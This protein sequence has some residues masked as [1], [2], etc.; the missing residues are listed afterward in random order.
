MRMQQKALI[1][2]A[3]PDWTNG[4]DE[5][6]MALQRGWRVARL[7]PMGGAGVIAYKGTPEACFAAL[8]VLERAVDAE[9]G[10]MEQV[11]EYPEE[12]RSEGDGAGGDLGDLGDR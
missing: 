8:V 10:V 3:H 5:L 1:V 9:A 12:G 4:L 11:E 7:S 2:M 6:N